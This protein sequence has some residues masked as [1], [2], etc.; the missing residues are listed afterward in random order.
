MDIKKVPYTNGI[1]EEI[2]GYLDLTDVLK[3]VQTDFEKE[4]TLRNEQGV[5]R[6][7]ERRRNF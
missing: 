2:K 7:E 1:S 3:D 6:E 4:E 5:R